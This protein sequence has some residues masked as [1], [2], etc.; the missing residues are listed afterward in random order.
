[1]KWRRK[2]KKT[3]RRVGKGIG[4]LGNLFGGRIGSIGGALESGA[5]VLQDKLG[6]KSPQWR[7]EQ[8]QSFDE[9]QE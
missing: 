6:D 2:K 4:I 7:K 3:Y 8:E 9:A 1:M 5:N